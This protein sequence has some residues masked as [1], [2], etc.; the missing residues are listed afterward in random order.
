MLGSLAQ[1]RRSISVAKAEIASGIEQRQ[2]EMLNNR[3]EVS[4]LHIRQREKITVRF[5]SPSKAREFFSIHD[6]NNTFS[7]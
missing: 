7:A 3:A 6:Q 4:H 1:S 2:H 5:K